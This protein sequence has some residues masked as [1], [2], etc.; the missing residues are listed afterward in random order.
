MHIDRRLSIHATFG[1]LFIILSA[2][3]ISALRAVQLSA[4]SSLV[5]SAARMTVGAQIGLLPALIATGVVVAL[6]L[7]ACTYVTVRRDLDARARTEVALRE[8]EERYRA[9]S[10][11]DELTGLYNR[12]G[13]CTLAEQQLRVA[14]R[15]GSDLLLLYIDMNRFKQINDQFGHA[16]GDRAL[17]AA[18]NV[19]R[20]TFRECDVVARMGGDEFTVLVVESSPAA[21]AAVL[22]RLEERLASQNLSSGRPYEL[23]MSV[24]I[25]RFEGN[26]A[27]SLDELLSAADESL[28]TSKRRRR[29]L[30]A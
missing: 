16:E 26:R 8:S 24:G 5:D 28:Y 13:F 18:G 10:V 1:G 11:T 29:W 7:A 23:S 27:A 6:V 14:R 20:A 17:G 25:A 21:E 2:L 15:N 9:A 4:A 12:R 19:L 30:V 22:A 3:T